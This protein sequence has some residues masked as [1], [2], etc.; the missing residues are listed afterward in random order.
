MTASPSSDKK[1]IDSKASGL[2]AIALAPERTHLKLVVPEGQLKVHSA[3]YRGSFSNVLSEAL[4]AAGLGSQVLV[5]QFLKG[6]VKQGPKDIVR[7]CGRLE[8]LRP[9]I[10]DCITEENAKPL[11]DQKEFGP[12]KA[13]QAIWGICKEYLLNGD[14]NQLVLDEIGL[15]T[16]LGYIDK[17]DL[18]STLEHRPKGMDVI[19]TGPSIPSE[20]IDMAD[21]VTEL[22]CGF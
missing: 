18:I 16:K 13:I 8:W 19:L 15:A 22:R 3:P 17:E 6:G 10:P 9:A 7:L 5:I 12:E 21:Q 14:I 20:I 2:R 11:L 4:R 1:L